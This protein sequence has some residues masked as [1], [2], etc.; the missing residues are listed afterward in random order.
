MRI[1]IVAVLGL[2]F[3]VSHPRPVAE[4]PLQV[5]PLGDVPAADL[6]LLRRDLSRTFTG[7]VQASPQRPLPREAWLKNRQQYDAA[8]ML[9]E[10]ARWPRSPGEKLLL[11]AAADGCRQDLSY[12]LGLAQPADGV[13]VVFL[14]RLGVDAGPERYHRRLLT[15]AHHELGHLLGLPHCDAP[16]CVMRY[17]HTVAD[18]DAKGSAFCARCRAEVSGE[19]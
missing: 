3:A 17:S 16:R 14:G 9:A 18:S 15:E 6:A 12:V 10:S 11:V 7:P 2:L 19:R 5:V 4:V 13:A 8:A 1:G